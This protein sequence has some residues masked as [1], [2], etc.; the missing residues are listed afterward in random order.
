[1]RALCA[2]ICLL[3]STAACHAATFGA[4]MHETVRHSVDADGIVR[5]R[6]ENTAGTVRVEG[7]AKSAIDV[8]AIKSGYSAEELR[9]IAIAI[10]RVGDVLRVQTLYKSDF[11]TGGVRYRI[12]VPARIALE[13]NNAAGTV[14]VAGLSGDLSIDTQ[15]GA[16]KADLGKVTLGRSVV[17]HATTG[18]IRASLARDS[19]VTI[20]AHT[21]VGS[22]SSDF[23][24]IAGRRESIVGMSAHG[25]LGSGSAR[26]ELTTTTGAISLLER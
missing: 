6:L 22:I 8:E 26:M 23:P 14:D 18:S 19:D 5:L 12:A 17:L 9:A 25:R 3:V 4:R 13:V 11:H 24:P 7:S 2:A 16:I 15:A 10:D 1:M 21:T 20:D